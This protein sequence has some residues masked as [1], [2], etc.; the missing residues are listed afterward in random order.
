MVLSRP[1]MPSQGHS[2]PFGSKATVFIHPAKNDLPKIFAGFEARLDMDLIGRTANNTRT[3]GGS[4]CHVQA[5]AK[6]RSVSEPQTSFAQAPGDGIAGKP[7]VD[8][9]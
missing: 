6:F 2:R 7:R 9:C 8:G 3:P 1:A 4:Y 5:Q